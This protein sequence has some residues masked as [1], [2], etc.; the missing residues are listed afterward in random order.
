MSEIIDEFKE[1]YP[2]CALFYV[3]FNDDENGNDDVVY[4]DIGIFITTHK[5]INSNEFYIIFNSMID[6]EED[7]VYSCF[8]VAKMQE[9]IIY[10]NSTLFSSS[11]CKLLINE[12]IF[13]EQD[14]KKYITIRLDR[15]LLPICNKYIF[16]FTKIIDDD[17]ELFFNDITYYQ[18][19]RNIL[20]NENHE[21]YKYYQKVAEYTIFSYIQ[22]Y[23]GNIT[24]NN[25]DE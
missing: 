10:I 17:L 19:Y 11:Y 7:L 18:G 9:N 3:D 21:L 1:Q 5:T 24:N 22:E 16:E 25:E 15:L 14:I 2:E 12:K 20:C 4:D 6:L 23:E 8:F 13:D